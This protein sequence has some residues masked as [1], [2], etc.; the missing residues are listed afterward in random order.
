MKHVAALTLSLLILA[1]AAQANSLCAE[2]E[3]EI[4]RQISYAEQHNNTHRAVGLKKALNEVQA[5]CTD[6]QLI[7]EH[8]EKIA[9]QK[10]EIIKRQSDLDKAH[11]KGDADKIVKREQKLAEAQSKLKSLEKRQY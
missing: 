2:K 6:S 1:P 8:Q 7:A 5:H 9:S 3:Q 11:L 10:R 4:Q